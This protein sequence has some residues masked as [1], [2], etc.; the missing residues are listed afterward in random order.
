MTLRSAL[1]AALSASAFVPAAAQPLAA[2]DAF[3]VR[4]D[5]ATIARSGASRVADLLRLAGAHAGHSLDGFRLSFDPAGS[6]SPL[7]PTWQLVVDGVPMPVGGPFDRH[8][9]LIPTVPGLVRE[10]RV[11][12]APSTRSAGGRIE[13][14]T[15]R[16]PEGLSIAGHVSAGNEVG[17]PGPYRYTPLA[18]PNADRI[19]PVFGFRGT[20][21]ADAWRVEGTYRGDEIHMTDPALEPRVRLLYRGTYRPRLLLAAPSLAVHRESARSRHRFQFH[22]GALRDLRLV[23]ETGSEVPSLSR[24]WAASAAGRQAIGR[25]WGVEYALDARQQDI[26]PRTADQSVAFDQ[27]FARLDAEFALRRESRRFAIGLSLGGRLRRLDPMPG[28]LDRTVAV[29]STRLD[30]AW[31]PTPGWR[32]AI[33]VETALSNEDPLRRNRLRHSATWLQRI[34]SPGGST[35]DLA[36]G[37]IVEM[38]EVAEQPA[39]W[40][41][42][43][44]RPPS[45]GADDESPR[46]TG[47]P[48]LLD[49]RTGSGQA[50]WTLRFRGGTTLALLGFGRVYRGHTLPQID[51]VAGPSLAPRLDGRERFAIGVGGALYGARIRVAGPA[52]AVAWHRLDLT[53][54]RPV[55]EGDEVYWRHAVTRPAV[56]ASWLASTQPVPRTSILVE[57]SARS[58]AS[59]PGF[60]PDPTTG[61]YAVLPS[62]V[63]VSIAV[64]KNLWGDRLLV[65]AAFRHALDRPFRTHP[66]GQSDR[67]ALHL[68][69]RAQLGYVPGES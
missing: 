19:G 65:Q 42:Q 57:A 6:S 49:A 44:W 9:E 36:A 66:F 41:L 21:R 8:P 61:G 7:F 52:S 10:V 58:S 27:V 31:Q 46:L 23:A 15:A 4:V 24:H 64:S 3:V 1:L 55:A 54:T 34:A 35:F 38:P 63:D 13:I 48:Y 67:L 14:D 29:P 39:W 53:W 56:E 28:V 26:L 16:P 60:V 32:H 20:V 12:T 33:A 51:L 62:R 59:W 5:S 43:G 37:W 2:A 17:D 50:E 22:F 30:V 18:T 69:I 25:R 45:I 68:G 47:A 40:I 11:I